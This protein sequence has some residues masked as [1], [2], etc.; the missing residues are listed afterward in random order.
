MLFRI[1]GAAG[2][3]L[4]HT[5][6]GDLVLR[7][8]GLRVVVGGEARPQSLRGTIVSASLEPATRET[9]PLSLSPLL[10]LG[11]ET[12]PVRIDR[13]DPRFH[14][15]TASLHLT[16]TAT[17][18]G[19]TFTVE[20]TLRALPD[21]PALALE[22][23][24]TAPPAWDGPP[25]RVGF[26]IAWGPGAAPFVPGF[27][28]LTDT[29]WHDAHWIG[30]AGPAPTAALAFSGTALRAR[31]GYDTHGEVRF[32]A[33]T[34]VVPADAASHRALLTLSTGDLSQTVRTLGHL[35]EAPFSEVT[36]RVPHNPPGS[37]VRV[38]TEDGRVIMR[39]RPRPADDDPS[40]GVVVAPITPLV[41]EALRE[42]YVAVAT[43][44]GHAA[45]DP[46][47]FGLGPD[48][49]VSVEIPRGGSVRVVALDAETQI[50]IPARVRF[51]G[52]EG[53]ATPDLG[54]EWRGPGAR[55]TVL[56]PEGGTIVP[57]PPGKY[58]VVVSRGPEWTLHTEVITV[59]ET[60]RAEVR[61]E[62]SHVVDPGDW[63]G[64]DLHLHAAPSSDSRVSLSDRVA[65]LAAEGVTFAVPTD[66]NVI[67]DYAPVLAAQPFGPEIT[68]IPGV[69]VTTWDPNFGHFN[70]FPVPFNGALPDNG[71]PRYTQQTPAGLFAAMR[72]LDPDTLV[73]VNH[74]RL[75]PDVGYFDHMQRDPRT[76][77]ALPHYSPDFDLLEVWNGFDIGRRTQV[78]RLFDEWLT[79]L[80]QG[81]RVVATGSSDSHNIRFQWAGYPR[82]YVR[83]DAGSRHDPRAVLRAL[84]AGRA[85]VTS[86]PFVEATLDGLGPGETVPSA[87]PTARLRV[88]VRAPAWM[89]LTRVEV[90][91]GP[92]VAVT[93]P[94]A[95]LPT[96]S[97]GAPPVVRFDRTLTIPV[98]PGSFVVVRVSGARGMT[99][100]LARGDATPLAF[101]NP[102]YLA[103]PPPPPEPAADAGADAAVDAAAD[104]ETDAETDADAPPSDAPSTDGSSP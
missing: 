44:W 23:T 92:A 4:A 64:C 52:V 66:H 73:Q 60:A 33:H 90:F 98:L 103:A 35:R 76:G 63:V 53:A 45:S 82:T 43:A 72:A 101:T 40:A 28:T 13:V 49:R 1:P 80:F 17:V 10:V 65:A 58:R 99:D 68:T 3:A 69:E 32:P 88:V 46:V 50:R 104:A 30:T 77:V 22:A 74:P 6:P 54:P 21:H 41:G 100:L 79:M 38:L 20:Q 26:R 37:S 89:D 59:T 96:R 18:A 57:L 31:L 2:A 36:V 93:A 47:F 29:A 91:S 24:V 87:A 51:K 15:N 11:D 102:I 16:G 9:D 56:L 84:R 62:L 67:T 81:H 78:D 39:G 75:E 8:H 48:A 14:D 34:D 70:A 95:P 7:A 94:I 86:G 19:H 12:T 55:D 97:R 85:F 71:A 5:L 83:V 61:A 42:R 25:A 27:G